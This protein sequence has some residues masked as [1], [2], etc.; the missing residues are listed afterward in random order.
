ML[1]QDRILLDF[2]KMMQS[3]VKRPIPGLTAN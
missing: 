2:K 3:K 1:K